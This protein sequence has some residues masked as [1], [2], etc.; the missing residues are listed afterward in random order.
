MTP[1][2]RP[3][4]IGKKPVSY[5]SATTIL[6]KASGFLSGYDY[7]LNPYVGCSF[8]CSYCY[9]ANFVANDTL[10][11]AW[12]EWVA[13]K[14]NAVELM[15]RK[16]PGTLDGKR[17]FMSSATDPYQPIER[18]L[19]LTRGVLEALTEHHTPKLVVQTRSPDVRRDID[20]F[21]RIELMG[22]K[23][24]VNMT[25]TTDDDD[26]RKV[27]EPDCPS[28]MARLAGISDVASK[29]VDTCITLTPL[30]LIRDV[31]SFSQRLIET[32]VPRFIIQSF[33]FAETNSNGFFKAST[34]QNAVHILASKLNCSVEK[35]V[36]SHSLHY[37]QVR[38]VLLER[39]PDLGEGRSGFAPPF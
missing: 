39:L 34:R 23:V 27:F 15:R 21:Q 25:V 4:S 13:V 35:A 33:K 2:T 26:I 7:T 12:G 31:D 28:L 22:G 10:K 6:A 37:K 3:S 17:I 36:E 11:Q 14:E 8:A 30:L 5:R 16:R 20:L 19:W 1:N 18:R 32:G 24:R 29:G 9:A 38:D